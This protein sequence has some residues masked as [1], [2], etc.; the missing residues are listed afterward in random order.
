MK[1]ILLALLTCFAFL[2]TAQTTW[3]PSKNGIPDKYEPRD[4][5]MSPNADVYLLCAQTTNSLQSAK[6]MKST[7]SGASWSEIPMNGLPA[8]LDPLAIQFASSTRVILAGLLS[9]GEYS[10]FVS[11]NNGQSWTGIPTGFP[12]TYN[13]QAMCIDGNGTVFVAG[14]KVSGN[15]TLP[16]LIKSVTMGSSWSEVTVSG[17]TGI[18]TAISAPGSKLLAATSSTNGFALMSSSDEG[19]NWSAIT[20]TITTDLVSPDLSSTGFGSIYLSGQD[21]GSIFYRS[22]DLGATWA[23]E[24]TT[25]HEDM[26][27]VNAILKSSGPLLTAGLG[28]ADSS[29]FVFSTAFTNSVGEN[30]PEFFNLYPVPA[31]NEL[32]LTFDHGSIQEV[33]FISTC[34]NVVKNQKSGFEK[35]SVSDL[36]K[37]VYHVRIVTSHGVIGRRIIVN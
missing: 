18:I 10:L 33:E 31:S 5:V 16:L 36:A 11:D 4:M 13:Y 34:G 37:G 1:T 27:R 30:L 26:T 19:K 23:E 25:G 7:N 22:N 20:S 32:N 12:V 2:L 3:Y 8:I 15:I 29:F 9:T 24:V 6:L 35:I 17:M 14:N 28:V 21:N